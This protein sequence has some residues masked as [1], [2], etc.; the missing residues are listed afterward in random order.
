MSFLNELRVFLLLSEFKKISVFNSHMFVR[1]PFVKYYCYYYAHYH[2]HCLQPLFPIYL[3]Y[4]SH[5]PQNHQIN[6]A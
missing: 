3:V 1:Y 2:Q 4:L 5:V 6:S